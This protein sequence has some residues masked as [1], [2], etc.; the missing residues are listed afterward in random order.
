MSAIEQL[1]SLPE[2]SIDNDKKRKL[3][4]SELNVLTKFHYSNCLQYKN[5]LN[6]LNIN[7]ETE[8]DNIEAVPYLPVRLFKTQKMQSIP[9]SEVLKV[10]ISSGTSD[11]QVSRIA[12]NRDTSLLQVKALASIITSYIGNKRL[13]MI[14]ID[15]D[16]TIR[17]KSSMS[18]RGAGLVGLSNFGR[19]HFFAL[20]ENMNLKVDEFIDFVEKYKSEPILIFGFTFMIWQY[21]YKKLKHLNKKADLSSA[22]LIHS[23]GWKKLLD[24]AVSNEIFKSELYDHFRLKK[25]YNFY[26]MVEQVGSIFMECEE[27]FLH[28]PNFAEVLIRDYVS[29]QTLSAGENGVIQT[30]SILPRSYPGHSLLTEDMGTIIGIDNCRC[31]RKGTYFTVSGRVPKAELRGCSDT[32]AETV[33]SAGS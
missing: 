32:H 5:I 16:A 29:W 18:A 19:N 2:Y 24:Q 22:I 7:P 26:G 4:L 15:T 12:L 31:G 14:I 6:N 20:D 11:Q 21:L 30:L 1:F 10:L 13:P 3:L 23:G 27:G 9:D 28:T 8:L 17:N 33:L 25:I